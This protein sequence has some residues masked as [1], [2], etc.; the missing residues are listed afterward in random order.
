MEIKDIVLISLFAA[1]T[2]VLALFPPITLPLIPAPIT[3]Q[4]LGVMLAG[5]ILGSKRGFLSITL[6][7]V[8]V[9]IGLPLLPGGGGGISVFFGL[10]GGFLISWPLAA[11]LMGWLV[12]KNWHHLSRVKIFFMCLVSGIGVVYLIGVP[13]LS[14]MANMSLASAFIGS[15]V[16]IVGDTVK[17]MIASSII[18]AISNY[19]PMI[20]QPSKDK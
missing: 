1:I 17:A 13:W 15:S 18:F 9:F 19:Y 5:G 7:L 4:T 14:Y 6:F 3:A 16:F 8:L 20:K 2:A 12:E 11:Y 10:T